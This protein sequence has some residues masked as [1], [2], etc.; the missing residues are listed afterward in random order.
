MKEPLS[1]HGA[2]EEIYIRSAAVIERMIVEIIEKKPVPVPQT[3]DVVAFKRRKPED[4]NMAK[5]LNLD[6]VYDYIRM[7]DAE[8]YP[9]AFLETEHLRLEFQRASRKD[10]TV[11]AD[12]RI[13][14]K[15]DRK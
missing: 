12:V 6:Q 13:M 3:G 10:R 9:N 14:I 1:L 5:L 2:A 4:G 8:D 7:L 15:E 11:I